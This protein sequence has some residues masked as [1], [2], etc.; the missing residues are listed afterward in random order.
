M[1]VNNS[2]MKKN[3][4]TVILMEEGLVGHPVV[5]KIQVRAGLRHFPNYG[6][7]VLVVSRP[8]NT[9]Y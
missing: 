8:T 6:D 4:I 1:T 3:Y 9:I 5:K 2:I 7:M